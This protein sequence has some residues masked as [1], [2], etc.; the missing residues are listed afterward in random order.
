[1][2][3]SVRTGR[4][5]RKPCSRVV[6]RRRARSGA[7][8]IEALRVPTAKGAAGSSWST[9]ALERLQ[10]PFGFR[11]RTHRRRAREAAGSAGSAHRSRTGGIARRCC[12]RPRCG[13]HGGRCCTVRASRVGCVAGRIVSS[14]VYR[15]GHC[16]GAVASYACCPIPSSRAWSSEP[17]LDRINWRPPSVSTS[18]SMPIQRGFASRG[19]RTGAGR[20]ASPRRRAPCARR[21]PSCSSPSTSRARATTRRSRST[22]A[23]ALPSTLPPAAR[24]SDVLQRSATAGLT[25][26]LTGTGR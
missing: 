16:G 20:P 21:R 6:Q 12:A 8:T 24:T 22:T 23:P 25:I 15:R 14:I 5:R 10:S 26:N 11:Q 13:G 19:S 4:S 7:P 2:A 1:M 18:L 3:P 17:T 9:L